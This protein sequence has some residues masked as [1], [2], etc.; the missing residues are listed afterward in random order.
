MKAIEISGLKKTFKK[1]NFCLQIDSL[2]ID[3]GSIVGL[4]G[5]NGAGKTTLL[6]LALDLLRPDQGHIRI[7]GHAPEDREALIPKIA[8]MPENKSLYENLTA[9]QMLLLAQKIVPLWDVEKA[10]HLLDTLSI[11]PAKKISTFSLGEKTLLYAIITFARSAS[12]YILDEPTRGLDPL[13]QERMLKLIKAH[14]LQNATII[15]SSHHLAEV[16]ETV[17]TIAMLKNGRIILQGDLDSIREDLF[18]I[19]CSPLIGNKISAAGFSVISSHLEGDHLT[20]LCQGG[21]AEKKRL[22]GAFDVSPIATNLKEIFISLMN[23]KGGN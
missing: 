3:Q 17:D 13:M 6:K 4:L 23:Q 16:E 5:P 10:A 9:R 22:Q 18:M 11:D 20:L 15:F 14:S 7:L 2:S 19:V 8:Y 21:E 1:S 12:L